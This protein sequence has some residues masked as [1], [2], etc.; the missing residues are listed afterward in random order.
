MVQDLQNLTEDPD[1][2]RMVDVRQQTNAS[3]VAKSALTYI[4]TGALAW[5]VSCSAAEARRFFHVQL[6]SFPTH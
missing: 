2:L 4:K 3:R 5:V 6:A 1:A